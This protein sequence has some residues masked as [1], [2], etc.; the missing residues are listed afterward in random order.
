MRRTTTTTTRYR[1]PAIRVY[2]ENPPGSRV[3]LVRTVRGRERERVVGPRGQLTLA[4]AAAVLDRPVA[5]VRKDIRA[6]FL[7]ARRDRGQAVVTL[8]GCDRFLREEREDGEGALAALEEMRRTGARPI[9][10]EQV[11]RELGLE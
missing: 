6:G 1:A 2:R 11:F 5:E 4:E 7:R 3:T 10:S 9:P 8:A